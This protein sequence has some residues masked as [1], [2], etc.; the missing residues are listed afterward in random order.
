[1]DSLARA[2]SL[3][4]KTVNPPGV[5]NSIP[6]TERVRPVPGVVCE[7]PLGWHMTTM[8]PR[9]D[10]PCSAVGFGMAE[11]FPAD[12]LCG[13]SATRHAEDSARR[14]VLIRGLDV[15]CEHGIS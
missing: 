3:V 6:L 2:T 14:T 13:V 11:S 12:G 5:I 1:M 7:D 8:P 9:F 10:E 15:T 4:A